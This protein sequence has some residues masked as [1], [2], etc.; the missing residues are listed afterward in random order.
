MAR[1]G[2][3]TKGVIYGTAGLLTTMAGLH[4]GGT[5]ADRRDAIHFI[6]R[7]PFGRVMLAIIA[8][9]LIGYAFWRVLSAVTD[10]ERRGSDFKGVVMRAGSVVR[11]LL[12]GT[13][14]YTVIRLLLHAGGSGRGSDA[15]SRHWTAR[16]LDHPLG[17]LLVIA[18]GISLIGYGAYQCYRAAGEGLSKPLD[19]SS[20]RATTK[21]R[22]MAMS[23]FG[24]AARGVVFGVIGVSLI[25]ASLHRNSGDAKGISGALRQLAGLPMGSWILTIA[26][27]GLASYG[28]YALINARFR[29]ITTA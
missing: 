7:Q 26:G 8:A 20:T 25:R 13:F 2:Y 24:V 18:A 12:Y 1:F 28:A 16:A 27:L 6:A 23:R 9:G 19:F 10:A 14:A 17:G 11:G 4:R 5:T 29:R 3:A 22:L 15:S 21:S